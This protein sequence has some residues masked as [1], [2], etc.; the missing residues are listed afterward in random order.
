MRLRVYFK[1]QRILEFWD[2]F[3]NYLFSMGVK[4]AWAAYKMSGIS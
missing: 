2:R 3:L 1:A 4:A